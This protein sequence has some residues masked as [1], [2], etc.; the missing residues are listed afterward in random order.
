MSVRVP[1]GLN[2]IIDTFGSLD[3]P[4]FE[5]RYI[6]PFS[7]PYPLFYEG[8]KVLRSR[9]HFL[10]V[11]IFKD[12]F[13]AIANSGL[14]DQVQ[15]YDGIFQMREIRGE[16]GSPSTHSWGIAIDLEPEKYPLGSSNRFSSEVIKIFSD[17]GFS[18][19]GDFASRKD[20][21]HFQYCTGY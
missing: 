20:P 13:Q 12:V 1:N 9:C 19:G 10:L 6:V 17:R 14:Q 3:V 5:Q 18:Y 15:N 21:M 7:L 16:N 8:E 11:D 2:E 4:D